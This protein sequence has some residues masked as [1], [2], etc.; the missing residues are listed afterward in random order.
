M[1]KLL[2]TIFYFVKQFIINNIKQFYSIQAKRVQIFLSHLDL[3][4]KNTHL[5]NIVTH[6][7]FFISQ[8]RSSSLI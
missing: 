2:N 3:Q 5:L 7:N 8:T 1:S 6:V 4:I